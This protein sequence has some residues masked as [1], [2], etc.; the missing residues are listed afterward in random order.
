MAAKA[1]EERLTYSRDAVLSKE[2]VAA[3]LGVSLRT[4]DKMDLPFTVIGYR[5]L[6]IRW[7]RVLDILDAR[8]IAA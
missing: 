7:G 3:A 1:Q 2:D 4:V 6:R 5:T 8:G